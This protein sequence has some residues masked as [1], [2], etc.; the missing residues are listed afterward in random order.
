MVQI[1]KNGCLNGSYVAQFADESTAGSI[2]INQQEK[3]SRNTKIAPSGRFCVYSE[4]I[5]FSSAICRLSII[6]TNRKRITIA[7]M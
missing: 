2:L 6:T 7:P 3:N 1:N 5:A 4:A